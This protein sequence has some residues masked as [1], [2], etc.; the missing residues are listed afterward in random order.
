VAPCDPEETEE[1][2]AVKYLTV[3]EVT[4]TDLAAFGVHLDP[5]M[6]ALLSL[7]AADSAVEDP[8]L[9][10]DLGT[11]RVDVQ[12]TVEAPDPAAAIVKALETL[13]AAIHAIG[14]S[15]SGWETTS[16][17]VHAA[18]AEAPGLLAPA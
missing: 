7:E 5:L 9:A 15:G 17:A 8:D 10:A 13:R 16:A 18:P 2:N 14:G 11:G 3:Q 4:C 1:R 12:I 6:E